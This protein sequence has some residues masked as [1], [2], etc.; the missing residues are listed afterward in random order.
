MNKDY[1]SLVKEE[2]LEVK[3]CYEISVECDANDGD[4]MSE[5]ITIKDLFSDELFF[6][7]LC[8]LSTEEAFGYPNKDHNNVFGNHIGGYAEGD[9]FF[10]WME[11]YCTEYKHTLLLFA[12]MCDYFCH[13][14]VDIE[15][16]HYVQG[17]AYRVILPNIDE[18][19][20]SID[21]M[22]DYMNKLYEAAI[23]VGKINYL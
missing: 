14:I 6:L 1:K 20:D 18:I 16:T 12:G 13:S 3:N 11:D 22:V 8:Y 9:Y 10:D 23:Q 17:M 4:Y 15:I 19:F 5:I 2:S 7:V 21:E